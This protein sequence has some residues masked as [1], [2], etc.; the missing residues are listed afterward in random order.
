MGLRRSLQPRRNHILLNHVSAPYVFRTVWWTSVLTARSETKDVHRP[1]PQILQQSLKSEQLI[2]TT[3]Q[4]V[5]LWSQTW[6]KR[7]PGIWTAE[8]QKGKQPYKKLLFSLTYFKTC[9]NFKVFSNTFTLIHFNTVVYFLFTE[10]TDEE[11]QII[12]EFINQTSWSTRGHL[13]S[14]NFITDSSL[15][16]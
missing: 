12:G 3:A 10:A 5:S 9:I 14:H 16:S 8:S 1:G 15:L 11:K 13:W 6:K 7:G 2:N 4:N